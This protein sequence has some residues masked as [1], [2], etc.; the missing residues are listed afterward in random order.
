MAREQLLYANDRDEIEI[1]EA[2]WKAWLDRNAPHL[3]FSHQG[4][5]NFL[6]DYFREAA[7]R[8]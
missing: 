2:G 5:L 3:E 1:D 7:K 6:R 8:R 4:I